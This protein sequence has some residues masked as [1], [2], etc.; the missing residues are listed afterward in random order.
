M[1]CACYR[2]T[3]HGRAAPDPRR[4]RRCPQNTEGARGAVRDL[5]DVALALFPSLALRERAWALRR[6]FTIADAMFIALAEQLGEPL[7]TKDQALAKEA[8]KHADA[9]IVVLT[10]DNRADS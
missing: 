9:E 1:R 7:A 8:S 4:S 6:N 10:A 5:G 3:A 2:Y